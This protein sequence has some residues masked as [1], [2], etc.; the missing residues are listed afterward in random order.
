MQIGRKPGGAERSRNGCQGILACLRDRHVSRRLGDRRVNRSPHISGLEMTVQ[1]T[2]GPKAQVA[3]RTFFA[4]KPGEHEFAAQ[5]RRKWRRLFG[6]LKRQLVDEFEVRRAANPAAKHGLRTTFGQWH[7]PVV[8]PSEEMRKPLV[9][10][11]RRKVETA[12]VSF[13]LEPARQT[14]AVEIKFGAWTQRVRGK[15]ERDGGEDGTLECIAGTDE[16][17]HARARLPREVLDTTITA[18]RELANLHRS[19]MP[20]SPWQGEHGVIFIARTHI[21]RRPFYAGW[22]QAR[23]PACRSRSARMS[24]KCPV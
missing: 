17:V 5:R 19:R 1:E 16:A 21:S 4:G 10:A 24:H 2:A 8:L 11:E 20:E 22:R 23:L 15:Q 9:R 6:A 18:D 7:R 3:R 13:D 12:N 14:A